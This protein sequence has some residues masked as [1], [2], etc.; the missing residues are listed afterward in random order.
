MAEHRDSAGPPPGPRVIEISSPSSEPFGRPLSA[1]RLRAAGENG[2]RAQVVYQ[3]AKCSG[4]GGPDEDTAANGFDAKPRDRER[5]KVGA[6]RGFQHDGTHWPAASGSAFYDRLWIQAAVAAGAARELARY[7]AYTDQFHRPGVSV[8]CQARAAAVLAGLE[9][10]RRIDRIYSTDQWAE[11]LQLGDE[12]RPGSS[13]SPAP[14][15]GSTT[16]G[17][18]QATRRPIPSGEACSTSTR[19]RRGSCNEV[20]GA[21]CRYCFCKRLGMNETTRPPTT[22]RPDQQR[23]AFGRQIRIEL[24]ADDQPGGLR[25]GRLDDRSVTAAEIHE[26]VPRTE[27]QQPEGDR[28]HA[29]VDP[30][31]RRTTAPG[32]RRG[33]TPAHEVADR[34]HQRGSRAERTQAVPHVRTDSRPRPAATHIHPRGPFLQAPCRNQT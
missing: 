30:P 31:E 25:A 27:A 15:K 11:T 26:T 5:R 23:P 34:G 13:S 10:S 4:D 2:D 22:C 1:M 21:Y 17:S 8:A 28:E 33:R 16:A 32:V 29:R 19:T 18:T 9:R 14:R 7:H 6:L 12:A 20:C 3:A 24:D